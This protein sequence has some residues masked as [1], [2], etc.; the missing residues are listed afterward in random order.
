MLP[1]D[2]LSANGLQGQY[3]HVIPSLGLAIVR[4]GATRFTG[5]ELDRFPPFALEVVRALETQRN[6]DAVKKLH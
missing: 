4:F 2:M 1:K 5:D 3:T 6:D